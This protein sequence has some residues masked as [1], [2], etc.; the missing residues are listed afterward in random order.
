MILFFKFLRSLLVK[1]FQILLL[2]SFLNFYFIL[3]DFSSNVC[4]NFINIWKLLKFR[5]LFN[6][7]I[8]VIT[9]FIA[10]KFYLMIIFNWFSLWILKW[11]KL[12]NTWTE[13]ILSSWNTYKSS[14]A[15]LFWK[16]SSLRFYINVFWFSFSLLILENIIYFKR[17]KTVLF[18]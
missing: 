11:A 12:R 17:L 9:V 14:W 7:F 16:W 8:S 5:F 13:S 10:L 2:L 1:L 6:W 18:K 3:C 4:R 15:S